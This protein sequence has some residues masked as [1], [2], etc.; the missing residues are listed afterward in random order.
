MVSITPTG[1]TQQYIKALDSATQLVIRARAIDGDEFI[2]LEY[3]YNTLGAYTPAER[4]S[5]RWGR[6]HAADSGILASTDTKGVYRL[7]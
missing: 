6:Q 1:L 4:T 5:V 7:L 2:T 3:L